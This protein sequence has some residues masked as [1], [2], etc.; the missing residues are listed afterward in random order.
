MRPLFSSSSR[1]ETQISA[2][3]SVKRN[4]NYANLFLYYVHWS[5]SQA[6]IPYVTY[7][8]VITLFACCLVVFC[9]LS[10]DRPYV[11]KGQAAGINAVFLILTNAHPGNQYD[12]IVEDQSGNFKDEFF[13]TA[14]NSVINYN[15]VPPAGVTI[16]V[17][18][19]IC[20]SQN[21]NC[22]NF[23]PAPNNFGTSSLTLNFPPQFVDSCR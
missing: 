10:F 9:V 14:D 13:V 8:D 16:N 3:S 2:G 23:I 19:K 21:P 18:D 5:P 20:P 15:Y 6:L 22:N 1:V 17:N 11:V 4:Y 7:F 12:L